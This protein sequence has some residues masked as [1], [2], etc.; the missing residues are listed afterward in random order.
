M[1]GTRTLQEAGRLIGCGDVKVIELID[2]G[3][4]QAIRVGN[5]RLVTVASLER[6]LGRSL[7]ELEAEPTSTP[8][9]SL[10]PAA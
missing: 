8:R 4:L 1:R 7:A 3:D 6:L 5:R 10:P 2:R 9:A